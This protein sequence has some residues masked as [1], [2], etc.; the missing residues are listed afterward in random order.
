MVVK[1][2]G[3]KH[4]GCSRVILTVTTSGSS[5]SEVFEVGEEAVADPARVM[6]S[7]RR[8]LLPLLGHSMVSWRLLP[9]RPHFLPLQEFL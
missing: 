1:W 6:R 4:I 7:S 9:Q 8:I 2:Y 5:H 3:N